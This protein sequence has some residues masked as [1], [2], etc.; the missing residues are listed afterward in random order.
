[1]EKQ[2]YEE[3]DELDVL[4]VGGGPLILNEIPR[5]PPDFSR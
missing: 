3:T 4:E 5:G 1:M 2:A